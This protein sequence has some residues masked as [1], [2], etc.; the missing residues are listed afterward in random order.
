MTIAQGRT[1][2]LFCFG[3]RAWLVNRGLD[4]LKEEKQTRSGSCRASRV[5]SHQSEVGTASGAYADS[6]S[7]SESEKDSEF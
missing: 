5:H 6:E 2:D 7:E 3:M 1:P 4:P